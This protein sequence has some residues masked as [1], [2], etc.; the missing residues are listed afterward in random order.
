MRINVGCGMSP[1]PGW[2]NFDNSY[3][4]TLSKRPLLARALGALGMLARHQS[5]YIAYCK[6]HAIEHADVRRRLPCADGSVEVI[7]SSHMLE[8][9]DQDD[10]R[11]FLE[12]ALRVLRPKGILRIAV[13]DLMYYAKKYVLD[14]DLQYFMYYTCLTRP[15]PRGLR[16]KLK[17][18]FVGDRHHKWMYDGP[19]LVQFLSE[20]G[21]SDPKVL[22]AAVTTIPDPGPLNLS[23]RHPESLYVEAG[24]P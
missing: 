18:L 15:T 24:K 4:I 23:E 2:R 1:T 12:E 9:L 20:C 19:H 22:P 6:T 17:Y 21:F 14:G 5:D 16:E 10:A 7:Y 8:H 11:R 3:V 13:P